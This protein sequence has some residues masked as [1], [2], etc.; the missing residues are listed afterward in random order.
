MSNCLQCRIIKYCGNHCVLGE[1]SVE[2][3]AEIIHRVYI[4]ELKQEAFWIIHGV[5]RTIVDVFE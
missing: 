3:I 2:V 1:E 5:P 4:V